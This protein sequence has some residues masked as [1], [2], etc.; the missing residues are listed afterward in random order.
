[1]K[2]PVENLYFM[3]C[4]AWDMLDEQKEVAV[5]V[6]EYTKLRDLLSRVLISGTYR[7]LH[8]GLDRGYLPFEAPLSQLR[9]QI[10]FRR[11][12]NAGALARCQL[13]CDYD[14]LDH[15]VIHN[16]IIKSTLLE[17]SQSDDVDPR[18]RTE[19]FNLAGEMIT[20]KLMLLRSNVFR[21][22]IF[23]RNRRA[24]AFLIKICQMI[25]ESL[26]PAEVGGGYEFMDFSQ[27]DARMWKLFQAF[28]RK[29][30]EH[31]LSGK[32]RVKAT[33]MDWQD[34]FSTPEDKA[35]LPTLNTDITMIRPEKAI[36]MDTKFYDDPFTR[37]Y[38]KPKLHGEH[39]YQ[40]LAYLQNYA[41]LYN[42]D[43]IEGILLYPTLNKTFVLSYSISGYPVRAAAIDLTQ[44]WAEMHNQM[45]TL[46]DA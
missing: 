22:L 44:D 39:L 29:F 15:D 27:D 25:F 19:A 13:F 17:L 46:I 18:L 20:I 4:Y 16:R 2:I 24:Y 40:I 23:D 5:N 11:S 7:L 9:G 10:N 30:Y 35:Y 3:L 14:D 43:Q 32:W 38:D 31:H 42:P 8:K 33:S 12:I 36:I 41:R 1:M 37:V 45:L 34:V 28:A 21:N 6:K 26:L